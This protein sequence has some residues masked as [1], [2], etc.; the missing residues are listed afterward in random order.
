MLSERAYTRF[1]I[2]T[3]RFAL[4]KYSVNSLAERHDREQTP[5]NTGPSVVSRT[6]RASHGRPDSLVGSRDTI[7]ITDIM[8]QESKRRFDDDEITFR[9]LLRDIRAS[10]IRLGTFIAACTLAGGVTGLFVERQYEASTV[11][12]PVTEEISG[13]VGGGLSALASQYSGLASLAG[14]NLGGMGGKKEE[15]IAVLQSELL[16]ER[17]IR[18]NDLLPVLFSKLWD[19]TTQKWTTSDPKKTPTLWKAN[20]YF[21]KIRGIVDDKKSGTVI[22]T[23]TW[24]DP[25]Q[26]AKWANDLV[27]ITNSYLREKAIQEAQRNIAYLNEQAAKTNVIEAQKSIYSLLE[28]EINKEMLARGRE[29]YA[30]KVLDPAFVPEKPSSAGP[31]L[32][33]LLGFGLGCTVSVLLVFGK[34]ALLT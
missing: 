31:V 14:I 8:D 20:G 1:G 3:R 25:K 32:L 30:L 24:K 18:D 11:L 17:Y 34:R 4:A 12:S 9:D 27:R 7:V 6:P 26:A 21:K 13:R 33:A 29:E 5:R 2:A 23:I 22:L 28:T 19:P 10:W 16:T 15:A